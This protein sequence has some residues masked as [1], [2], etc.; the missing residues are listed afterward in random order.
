MKVICYG[1]SN[2]YGFDPRSFF[3]SRY[4]APW[5]QLLAKLTGW[6]VINQGENG[7][8]IPKV[9]VSFPDDT[10]LLILMLGTNDLLQSRTSE[11]TTQRMAHFLTSLDLDR[12][13][14]LLLAPPPMTLGEWVADAGLIQAAQALADCYESLASDLDIRFARI[15]CGK[16]MAYDGVHLTQ[17]GHRLFA[18]NLYDYLHNGG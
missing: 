5:P 10:D 13:K 6:Q 16:A 3:G 17:E 9:Q 2:T 7:R 1:D 15:D 14:I 4:E 12:E 8:E 11:E 18:Q